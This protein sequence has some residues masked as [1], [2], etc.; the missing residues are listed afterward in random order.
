MTSK[1]P[2]FAASLFFA[3][4]CVPTAVQA[5]GYGVTFTRPAP[6]YPYE[7]QPGQPYAV[8][9]APN[10]FV[11]HRPRLDYPYVARPQVHRAQRAVVHTPPER[12]RQADL[13]LQQ[14]VKTGAQRVIEADAVVTIL[15]PDR[16][17]IRL[18]RKRGADARAH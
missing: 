4:A 2:L 18:L 7:L 10:A 9:I 1:P 8:E 14:A 15:G 11:I 13:D 5:Q 12:V 16:M 6:L 3:A 17:N